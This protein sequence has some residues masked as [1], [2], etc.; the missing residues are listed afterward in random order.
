[1]TSREENR[2]AGRLVLMGAGGV[3]GITAVHCSVGALM[4]IIPSAAISDLVGQES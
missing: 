4:D 3:N 2:L 1:L